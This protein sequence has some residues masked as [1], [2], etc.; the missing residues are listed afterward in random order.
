MRRAV[1]LTAS[2]VFIGFLVACG[3]R[4]KT[5]SPLPP[6]PKPVT[7]PT[8]KE[9]VKATKKTE[10]AKAAPVIDYLAVHKAYLENPIAA[11][12]THFGKTYRDT[13]MVSVFMPG[14]V[15]GQRV[16][17]LRS[18]HKDVEKLSLANGGAT[19]GTI[20]TMSEEDV[21]TLKKDQIITVE[22]Q[23]VEYD[24]S[25]AGGG[26][27]SFYMARCRIVREKN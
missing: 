12:K 2:V 22:G 27:V 13:G 23:L 17:V 14:K 15:A 20:C 4:T 3:S 5:S 9:V 24:R 6:T 21:V 8:E 25:D 7:P 1:A 10:A 16:V 26:I 11:E 19:I 18:A